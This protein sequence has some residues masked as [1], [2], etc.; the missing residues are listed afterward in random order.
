MGSENMDEKYWVRSL[1][2]ANLVMNLIAKEPGKYRLIDISKSLN[3]NKSSIFSILNTLEFLGWVTKEKGNTYKL[4]PTLGAYITAYSRNFNLLESFNMEA[5]KTLK[6][7]DENILLGV[8]NGTNVLCLGAQEKNSIV[9][10]ATDVGMQFPAHAT[11]FGKIQ[12]IKYSYY[13]LIDLY[14]DQELE[15][16]TPNTIKTVGELWNQLESARWSGYTIDDQEYI[17]GCYSISAPV[18]NHKNS[19]ICGVCCTMLENSWNEKKDKAILEIVDLAKRLS[20]L[21]GYTQP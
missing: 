16:F 12:L 21:A 20:E 9:R 17:Q 8:L 11:S 14:T 4:G 18:Y 13:E 6:K 2:R 15:Q 3:I 7:L 5:E 19:L 10:I 1:E